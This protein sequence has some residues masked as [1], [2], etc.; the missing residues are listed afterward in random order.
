MYR[1]EE[2]QRKKALEQFK[3]F[4]TKRISDKNTQ[5]QICKQG[6]NDLNLKISKLKNANIIK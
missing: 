4:N 5:K 2:K 6:L 3:R 1:D